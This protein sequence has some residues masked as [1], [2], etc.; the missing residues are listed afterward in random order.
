MPKINIRSTIHAC[1]AAGTL[2][3]AGI[4][5]TT[6]AGPAASQGP[7]TTVM[8]EYAVKF[9]CGPMAVNPPGSRP[10][11]GGGYATAVN[12]HNPGQAMPVGRKVALAPEAR[13]G[14]ITGFQQT[15]LGY[16]QAID[17]TCRHIFAQANIPPNVFATGFLV[18]RAPRD[19]DVVAVYTAAPL[20]GQVATM[21]TER[22]PLRRV[23]VPIT[24][25][26]GGTKAD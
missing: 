20:N 12:I 3:V 25:G 5:A 11:V 7:T 8:N 21:H 16:D 1:A 2:V 13:P 9:V 14:P 22:V 15:D 10:V 6:L 23:V 17:F 26:S 24:V 19:L 18:I 4:L